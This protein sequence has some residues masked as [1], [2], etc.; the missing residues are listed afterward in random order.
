MKPYLPLPPARVGA[1]RPLRGGVARVA[2]RE[3][4][5]AA[6]AA[7]NARE[8]DGTPGA[9]YRV[10]ALV[11][12][13]AGCASVPTRLDQPVLRDH[14]PLAGLELPTRDGWPQPQW[15]R[16]YHDDQLDALMA[17]AMAQAPDLAVAQARVRS[18]EQS[19]RMVAAQAGLSI[20]GQA[21]VARQR[22][23]D[24]GLIPSQFLGFSWYNQADLGA[25]L[26]YEFD[27]WGKKRGTIESAL[28]QT[29]AAMAL[30][31]AAALS[32]QY[33]VANTYFAW[34]ADTARIQLA[35]QAVAAKQQLAHIAQLRVAQGVDLPDSA[36]AARA[37]VAAAREMLV[38]WKVRHGFAT[39]PWRRCW[40]SPRVTCHDCNR[41]RYL[42]WKPG[43]RPMPAS[44]CWRGDRTSPPTCGRCKP[45][46]GKPTW[47]GREFYRTSASVR[48]PACR[49]SSW[50]SC[51]PP[52]VGYLPWR[53]RCTCRFSAADA[54]RPTTALRARNW[55][56][57]SR[58]TTPPW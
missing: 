37:Q 41:S 5:P 11:L 22:I 50:T 57:P 31:S 9:C 48:W 21:Q 1:G 13:V 19:A 28:D 54:C 38:A 27:W 47:R 53:R 6:L 43:C 12:L 56:A 33:A 23:T 44:T 36:P 42:Q 4:H 58:N 2:S 46:S 29:H 51:S 7:R 20:A 49:V 16:V 26:Q 34:Q 25:Q 40:A 52:A 35:Q 17:R 32:I 10:A 18:A 14:V 39:R 45:R 15:W 8:T 24:H 30:R 55:T 3:A